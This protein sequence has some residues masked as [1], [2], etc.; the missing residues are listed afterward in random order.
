MEGNRPRYTNFTISRTRDDVLYPRLMAFFPRRPPNHP[1]KNR[2][3][4]RA[5]LYEPDL[6][7]LFSLE[8]SSSLPQVWTSR[9]KGSDDGLL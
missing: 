1:Q 6:C 8:P 4:L 7:S 3:Q 5:L 9:S 2:V